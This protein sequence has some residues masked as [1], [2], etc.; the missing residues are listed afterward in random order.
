MIVAVIIYFAGF[1]KLIRDLLSRKHEKKAREAAVA[2]HTEDVAETTEDGE[3][4]PAGD[5]GIGILPKTHD[6]ADDESVEEA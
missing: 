3:M 2:A 1:S 4:P 5:S 6:G